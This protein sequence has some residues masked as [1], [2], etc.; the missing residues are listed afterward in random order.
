MALARPVPEA[1]IDALD[2]GIED[3]R[4]PNGSRRPGGDP[5]ARERP[6]AA[7][8]PAPERPVHSPDKGIRRTGGGTHADRGVR[9]PAARR[10]PGPA[11]GAGGGVE[12]EPIG[13]ALQENTGA[14]GGGANPEDG[15]IRLDGA[16]TVLP[17]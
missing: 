17:A 14:G 10:R 8:R 12:V 6:G 4:A 16:D 9:D 5:A 2:E 7:A 13:G 11:L 1:A 15:V 3:A